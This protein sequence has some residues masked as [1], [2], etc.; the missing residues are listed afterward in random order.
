MTL[1]VDLKTRQLLDSVEIGGISEH[2]ALSSSGK[3]VEA[4][5]AIGQE[6]GFIRIFAI[7]G[8]KLREVASAQS[9]NWPQGATWSKDD[10]TILLA[11]MR[12]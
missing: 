3:Y 4:T 1:A 10:R 8:G 6:R 12:R 2:V 11:A 7:D 5:V 9:G